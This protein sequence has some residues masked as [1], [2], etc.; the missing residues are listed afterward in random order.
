MS[1]MG[2]VRRRILKPLGLR[3]WSVE[4]VD[5]IGAEFGIN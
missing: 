4:K 1:K 3:K 2:Q 5:T